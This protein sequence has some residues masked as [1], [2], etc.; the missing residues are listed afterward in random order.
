LTPKPRRLPLLGPSL[1]RQLPCPRF[2]RPLSVLFFGSPPPFCFF[3]SL[4]L[5]GATF[6]S[7]RGHFNHTIKTRFFLRCASFFAYVRFPQSPWSDEPSPFPLVVTSAPLRPHLDSFALMLFVGPSFFLLSLSS[8]YL[9]D[10][11][12]SAQCFFDSSVR[13]LGLTFQLPLPS[14][15]TLLPPHC[16]LTPK[17]PVLHCYCLALFLARNFFS[18]VPP[19]LFFHGPIFSPACHVCFPPPPLS[20]NPSTGGSLEEFFFLWESVD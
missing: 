12:W 18:F 1:P 19:G 17:G 16:D 8:S 10:L 13:C 4:F 9:F 7:Q 2:G 15:F 6:R 11:C 3:A 14:S 5:Y 20:G